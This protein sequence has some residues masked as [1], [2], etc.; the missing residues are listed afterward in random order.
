MHSNK[1]QALTFIFAVAIWLT[2]SGFTGLESY[3]SGT[4][5]DEIG[6]LS[7]EQT[8]ELAAPDS[9]DELNTGI[10]SS[11]VENISG[12]QGYALMQILDWSDKCMANVEK[13]AEIK[14]A[15]SKDAER[16]GEI[17]KGDMA[18][19][20][21]Q[22][23]GWTHIQS[24]N[25]E[26]WVL[27]E[28]LAFGEDAIKRAEEDTKKTG[29]ASVGDLTIYEKPDRGSMVLGT[30]SEGEE[31]ELGGEVEGF[32]EVIYSDGGTA[33][34]PAEYVT[35]SYGY[36][37][38]KT[39]EEIEEE[40]RA[41]QYAARTAR[42]SA[43]AATADELDLLAALIQA[44]A[45]NQP[46]EGQLAVGAVVMNRVKSPK[47]PNTIYGVISQPGQFTPWGTGRVQ[48]ILAGGAN[49]SCYAAAQAALNGETTVGQCLFFRVNDGRNGIVIG[50]HVFY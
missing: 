16:A 1:T 9:L 13:S 40:E 10:L 39:Q 15:P 12:T 26:G 2:S 4:L 29:T 22:S 20:L 24:G 8:L 44:E 36:G 28:Y 25:A 5:P 17:Y 3:G 45:G 42:L 46:Y 33:Y 18:Y 47:F 34:V 30:F 23:D 49:A 48:S 31:F 7:E 43:V 19:I 14:A 41:R 37:E 21:E 38:A 27:N 35:V 32:F 11:G 50:A 6:S